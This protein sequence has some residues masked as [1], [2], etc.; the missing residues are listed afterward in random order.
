VTLG[1]ADFSGGDESRLLKAVI[2]PEHLNPSKTFRLFVFENMRWSPNDC[3]PTVGPQARR[4]RREA[5]CRI[6]SPPNDYLVS[7]SRSGVENQ[8]TNPRERFQS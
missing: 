1:D 5:R 4:A 6:C 7:T 3:V 8:R 2:S